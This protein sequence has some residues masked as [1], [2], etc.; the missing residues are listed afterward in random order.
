MTE[1]DEQTGVDKDNQVHITLE[2][3]ALYVKL[4]LAKAPQT[5][6]SIKKETSKEEI[7]FGRKSHPNA[8]NVG[9]EYIHLQNRGVKGNLGAK[10]W[11]KLILFALSAHAE[12]QGI[13]TVQKVKDKPIRNSGG[14]T[15]AGR[16]PFS[17][18]LSLSSFIF[19]SG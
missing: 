13:F 6:D 3:K 17:T 15:Y 16:S 1:S 19:C 10:K 4:G 5:L 2:S 18:K 9:R 8:L 11:L 12:A 7:F 14:S